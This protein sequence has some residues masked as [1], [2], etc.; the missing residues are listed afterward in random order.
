M[1]VAG[2]IPEYNFAV[3]CPAEKDRKFVVEADEPFEHRGRAGHGGPSGIGLVR[4]HDPRLTLAVIAEA[5]GLQHGRRTD[6]RQSRVEPGPVV[7]RRERGGA[8]AQAG[9]EALFLQPVLRDLQRPGR[10]VQRLEPGQRG[11]GDILEFVGDDVHAR[12]EPRQ[13]GR[14]AERALREMAGDLGGNTVGIGCVDMGAIAELRGGD[15]KHPP[16]LAAADDADGGAGR[17]GHESIF[18][19]ELRSP[20]RS[21]PAATVRAAPPAPGR[22]RRGSRRRADPH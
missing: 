5:P 13:R 3:G 20:R 18:I 10:R 14:I 4:H 6:L 2:R 21:G 15:R 12:R 19:P 22:C 17:D 7:D 11:G 9:H 8:S 1:Q 16:Q